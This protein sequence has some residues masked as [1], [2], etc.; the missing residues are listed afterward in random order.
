MKA[1]ILDAA[2]QS[3]EAEKMLEQGLG[4]STFR[5]QVVQQAAMLLLQHH[6]PAEA[7]K[8]LR[9][10]LKSNAENAD[11]LLT[12]AIALALMNQNSEA[13]KALKEVELLWPEWDRPYLV[14]GLMLERGGRPREARQKL[15]MAI[16]LG[17]QEP[18]GRCALNRLVAS[19]DPDPQCA[20]RVGLHDLLFP[21]CDRR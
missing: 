5:A 10:T 7:L 3:A 17:S 13:E 4:R 21:T 19:P 12:N 9:A 16:A 11:L 1:T 15:R 8:I 14:H 2:G 20:C 6:R 18:A